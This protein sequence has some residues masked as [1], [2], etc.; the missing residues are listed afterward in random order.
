MALVEPAEAPNKVMAE[1]N[2]AWLEQL[3]GVVA[4]LAREWLPRVGATL[5]GGHAAFVVEE[6]L[7]TGRR[8]S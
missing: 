5:G 3:P 6:T 7:G 8:R 1:G 4:S 2:G